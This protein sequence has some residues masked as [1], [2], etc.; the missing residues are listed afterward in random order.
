MNKKKGQWIGNSNIPAAH[1]G[2]APSSSYPCSQTTLHLDPE[3]VRK[4]FVCT[5]EFGISGGEHGAAYNGKMP[6][7][8]RSTSNNLPRHVGSSCQTPCRQI[9]SPPALTWFGRQL[10]SYVSPEST[11][12][13]LTRASEY[14]M[15]GAMRHCPKNKSK[16]TQNFIGFDKETSYP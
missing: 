8:R 1:D 5:N 4:Q 9:G 11:V 12:S 6:A 10:T 3:S 13:K 16:L 14:G 7:G 2:F 15:L